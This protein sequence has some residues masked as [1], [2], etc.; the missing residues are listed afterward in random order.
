MASLE[1]AGL[2][3]G[4]TIQTHSKAKN[5]ILTINEKVIP[6]TSD[7]LKYVENLKSF[8]YVLVTEHFGQENRHYHMYIQLNQCIALSVKK[9]FGAHIDKCFGSAQQNIAY[10]KCEDEKHKKLGISYELIYEKGEPKFKG[11]YHTVGDIKE[12]NEENLDEL[13]IMYY[14]VAKQIMYDKQSDIDVDAWHKDVKVFYIQGPSGIGKTE[15][16]KNIVRGLKHVYGTKINIV[17]YENGFWCGTGSAKIAIYDD[18]R[19]SHLKASE[20]INFI[21]Y[22]THYLNV[23][24]GS[25]LNDYNLIIITSVQKLDEIYKNMDDE[26]RKQ[27]IRRVELINMYESENDIDVDA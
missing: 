12:M 20:F 13:P 2:G 8:Q 10:L 9:L 21:D 18:F 23:K 19:D 5:Y 22:N 15:K 17:K 25:K 7:I 26:P 27:W 24:G 14:K 6:H 3:S 11:G 16:A 4:N 1:M